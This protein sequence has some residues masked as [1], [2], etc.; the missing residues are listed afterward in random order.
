MKI[1]MAHG[2]G[3]ESTSQLRVEFYSKVQRKKEADL[4]LAQKYT[5]EYEAVLNYY[6]KLAT[7]ASE[8]NEKL[9]NASDELKKVNAAI[10]NLTTN[11]V[12]GEPNDKVT[13]R[14][15]DLKEQY[16]E[17]KAAFAAAQKAQKNA[18]DELAKAEEKLADKKAEIAEIIR[19]NAENSAKSNQSDDN[20]NAD[21]VYS[22]DNDL[23]NEADST[24]DVITAVATAKTLT[25]KVPSLAVNT[26]AVPAVLGAKKSSKAGTKIATVNVVAKADSNDTQ[27]AGSD[28]TVAVSEDA[29][30]TEENNAKSEEST[31]SENKNDLNGGATEIAETEMPLAA[32]PSEKKSPL[33][34]VIVAILAAVGISVEEVVRRNSKKNKA[35]QKSDK[36]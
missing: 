30:M 15:N 24:V 36:K 13:K 20:R 33:P 4:E 1:T 12:T 25:A 19:R 16:K 27:V 6:N 34:A 3:G 22:G 2:S 29:A 21:A 11:D 10:D 9:N 5:K 31:T 35:D 18:N 17:A 8:A 7:A 32:A 26:Q 28:A 23:G 14:L